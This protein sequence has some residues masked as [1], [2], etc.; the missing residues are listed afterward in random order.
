MDL[1]PR[2]TARDRDATRAWEDG[3]LDWLVDADFGKQKGSAA[4]NHGAFHHT[5]VAAL[6]AATC[7]TALALRT[8]AAARTGLISPR[9]GADGGRPQELAPTRSRHYSAFNPVAFT[10]LAAVGDR[11]D[12]R[13]RTGPEGSSLRQAVGFLLPAATG[14]APWP[15]PEPDVP[16]YAAS[17][18]VHAAAD[19]GDRRARAAPA[20]LEAPPGGDR[21]ALRP[22]PEQLDGITG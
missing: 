20:D 5:Q 8:V 3:F 19:R 16:A 7:S 22:A 14:A 18:V 21:W 6:A 13:H 2:W 9:I 17:E 15:H 11:V 12:L 1:A 4:N 10:R